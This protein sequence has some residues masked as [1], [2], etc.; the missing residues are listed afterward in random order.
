MKLVV[1]ESE[2]DELRSFVDGARL[3]SSQIALAEVPRACHRIADGDTSVD[4]DRLLRQADRQLG[5]LDLLP[6]ESE[7][8][9]SAGALQEP[10]LRSLDAIHVATAIYF[11]ELDGFVT[12]DRRQAAVA[13]LAGFPTYSPGV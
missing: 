5:S 7:L 9:R 12:Y 3:A 8:L 10:H 1:P 4:L 2:S 6:L 11:V 13:R